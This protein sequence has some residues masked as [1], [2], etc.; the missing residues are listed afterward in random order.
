M[1]SNEK[2]KLEYLYAEIDDNP[3]EE[4]IKKLKEQEEIKDKEE[5]G[6]III[7]MF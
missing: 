7:D 2:E 5:R 1:K 6:I 3:P 4:Y